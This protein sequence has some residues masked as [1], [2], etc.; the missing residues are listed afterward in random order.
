MQIIVIQPGSQAAL[1]L[2]QAHQIACSS[3]SST[4]ESSEV[5]CEMN[6]EDN[7]RK[8]PARKRQR[9]DHMT[10]QE[11]FLRR[12]MKNRVAAQTARDKKKAKMDELEEIVSNLRAENNRLRA[13]NQ[14]LL[15]E[16]ARLTGNQLTGNHSIDVQEDLVSKSVER[17]YPVESAALINGPLPQG[18]GYIPSMV[19]KLLLHLMLVLQSPAVH[20]KSSK[21]KK[22]TMADI[23]IPEAP[24]IAIKEVEGKIDILNWLTKA[25]L[26]SEDVDVDAKNLSCP[27]KSETA[28]FDLL[29]YVEASDDGANLDEKI[30]DS[31][32]SFE[33]QTI[34]DFSS[35]LAKSFPEI[36]ECNNDLLERAIECPASP[37]C[38]SEEIVDYVENTNS[39]SGS[40]ICEED[41]QEPDWLSTWDCV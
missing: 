35:E 25:V 24:T 27:T 32:M 10:E 30:I 33:T 2:A 31:L 9:L 34:V 15:A 29:Q 3:S 36:R 41:M 7:S 14:R 22:F 37:F 39:I 11:K 21:L 5:E 8:Q 6:G 13:E 16:N 38:K 23:H 20:L 19:L 4:G 18:Q 17:M 28:E 40:P 26:E 12:K 1:G